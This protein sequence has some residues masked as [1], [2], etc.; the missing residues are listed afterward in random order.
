MKRKLLV[1]GWDSA[2]WK[3]INPLLD[4]GLMPNLEKMING[5]VI[6]NLATLKPALSPMLWTSI[7]TGKRPF[8]HGIIGFTEATEDGKGV[9][10]VTVL[11]R[12]CK[13]IWNILT[14]QDLKTHVVAWWPSHPAEKINGI[15]IS[16]FYQRAERPID[17]PWVMKPGTVHPESM[18]DFF[19]S[20][21]IHPSEF[22]MEHIH[23]FVPE[24]GKIDES[25]VKPLNNITKILADCATVHAAGTYILENEEW[26]FAGIYYDSIDHFNHGFMRYN[27][28]MREGMSA[29]LF[30]YFKNVVSSAYRFHDMMLGRLM[31]LAGDDA[32]IMLISDHGFHPDHLRPE[33][34]TAEPASPATEHSPYGIF[35]IKGPGIKKDEIIYGASLLDITPTILSLYDLPIG[36]DMDGKPLLDIYEEIPKVKTIDSWENVEGY[37]GMHDKSVQLPADFN[38]QSLQQLVELGYIE[39]PKK[40]GANAA[41][42]TVREN[43]FYLAEAYMDA[44]KFDEAADLLQKLFDEQPLVRYG[45]QLAVCYE[46]LRKAEECRKVIDKVKEV[47]DLRYKKAIKI[48]EE[49]KDPKYDGK[50]KLNRPLNPA[51]MNYVLEISALMAEGKYKDAL[52]AFSEMEK[53]GDPL[54]GL[55]TRKAKC[56]V[57][58]KRYGLAIAELDKEIEHN[59]DSPESHE[60]KGYCLLQLKKYEK[61]ADSFLTAA[62]LRFNSPFLHYY[63]GECFYKLNRYE[64]ALGAYRVAL[65]MNPYL[66][67][68][69]LR[70]VKIYKEH[71]NQPEKALE[72]TQQITEN[73]VGEI[74]VVSG[75]PRSGTSMMMQILHAGGVPVMTDER[76]WADDNNPLG[77]YE[78]EPVK[79]LAKD[80]KWLQDAEGKVVKVISQ[81]LYFLPQNYRYKIIYMNRDLDEV[82][83]SQQKMLG[84]SQQEVSMAVYES[85]RK[86]HEKMK[87]WVEKRPNVSLMEVNYAGVIDNP[88]E[89]CRKIKEFLKKDLDLEKMAG[90]VS[91]SLYRNRQVAAGTK[92]E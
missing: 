31:N 35:C 8:K 73:V 68:A 66:N 72:Y 13:A 48:F 80:A 62:G 41:Q 86:E 61:A 44:Q 85:F 37:S 25:K 91:S 32:T 38:E 81:L 56:L 83:Q 60:S 42:S 51:R 33:Y 11:H 47:L 65:K 30:N 89:E 92:Q 28:P 21:R 76:R 75:L 77:Y 3:V 78:Y 12:Q 84:K 19:G 39:D 63:L 55:H 54:T 53:T 18:R 46:R 29:E 90:K 34:I 49:Q 70:I 45:K 17:E 24:F 82:M 74:I 5:G 43:N 20:L 4:Q 52:N 22:S 15:C 88:E 14:Q 9:K 23:P 58:L 10:P 40:Q 57:E 67:K 7:A 64:D 6:G 1:I 87:K 69:R 59:F 71:L 27:P 50:R 16:N 2:D 26:D 79:N 36:Q